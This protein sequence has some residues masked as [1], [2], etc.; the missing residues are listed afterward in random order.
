[1]I[2]KNDKR[3]GKRIQRLR[4]KAGL[5]QEQ[6]AEKVGISMK[7]VQFIENARRIPALKTLYKIARALGV[8][9]SDLF[10]A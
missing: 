10:K 8:K 7:Y 4:K 9:S 3:L 2:T 6:L 1:M 5:T